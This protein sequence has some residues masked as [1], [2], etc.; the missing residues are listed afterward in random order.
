VARQFCPSVRD[1]YIDLL[2]RNV[3][4]A[5]DFD[6]KSLLHLQSLPEQS[7]LQVLA[8]L[9]TNRQQ[10]R[11]KSAFL[12]SVC[13]RARRGALDVRGFGGVD[14]FSAQLDSLVSK[15]SK[16]LPLVPEE[17]FLALHPGTVVA[18]VLGDRVAKFPLTA[19][20]SDLGN[21]RLRHAVLGVLRESRS[22]A[23]YNFRSSEVLEALPRRRG[24]RRVNKHE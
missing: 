14:V 10:V 16:I 5:T 21:I 1:K 7:Q 24:G 3:I 9:E 17:E 11:S 23:F 12:V 6:S 2:T 20:I 13:E 8:H 22:L 15:S 19:K 4:K 18:V